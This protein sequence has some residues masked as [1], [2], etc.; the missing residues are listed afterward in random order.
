MFEGSLFTFYKDPYCKIPVFLMGG[1]SLRAQRCVLWIG[2]QSESFLCFNYFPRLAEMLSGD[3]AFAQVEL[4]SSRVGFGAQDHVHDAEDVD[5]LLSILVKDYDMREITLFAT[6]TGVQVVFE[7]LANG[8]HTAFVTRA[9]LHGVVCDPASPLFTPEGVAA[10]AEFVA[11]LVAAGRQEDSRALVDHYDIPVTPA[12]LAGGGFPTLQEAVWSPCMRGEVDTLQQSIGRVR[13]PML[14]MLAHHAQYKPT[15]EEVDKV[16]RL[17][18]EYAGCTHVTVSYFKDT[19][20]ERRRVLKAAEQE[21]VDAILHFL[22]EEDDR[23][24]KQEKE[25]QWRAVEEEKKRKSILQA[26]AFAKNLARNSTA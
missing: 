17:V 19:C 2:G 16:V 11:E 26:N 21:H 14:I 4:P 25:E 24:A 1:G 12:R 23:R 6:S 13:V 7:L 10:R 5:E 22:A 20:D 8:R 9:I 15:P 3:W 18:R